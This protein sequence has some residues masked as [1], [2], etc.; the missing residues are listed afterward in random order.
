MGRFTITGGRIGARPLAAL[1]SALIL[2]GLSGASGVLASKP[3]TENQLLQASGSIFCDGAVRGSGAHIQQPLKDYSIIVTAAHVLVDH[4]TQRRFKTCWYRGN[5]AR[6]AAV[7]FAQISALI[8]SS[9]DRPAIQQSESDLV[10][11]ALKRRLY[12]PALR[13]KTE[14]KPVPSMPI[15]SVPIPSVIDAPFIATPLAQIG[16]HTSSDTMRIARGCASLAT[17]YF[18]NKNLLLHDCPTGPGA[19]GG[20][21]IDDRDQRLV[22]VHGG[23]LLIE[24][25]KRDRDRDRRYRGLEH[26]EEVDQKGAWQNSQ[27]SNQ[28]MAQQPMQLEIRQG[29]AIDAQVLRQL[30]DFIRRLVQ[31]LD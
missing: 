28:T 6:F 24:H 19:S 22:A 9:S 27:R 23:T 14:N 7:P 10:F 11:I 13:L 21:L 29:R 25:L 17:P 26:N 18:Y 15:P 4:R 30:D 16:Y 2:A 1:N 12:A 5:N 3:L 8:D 31:P 20:P